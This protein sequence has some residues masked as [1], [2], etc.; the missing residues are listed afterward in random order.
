M[1]L[2]SPESLETGRRLLQ[3]HGSWS[4]V[5]EHSRRGKSGVFVVKPQN[6]GK[7]VELQRALDK[8]AG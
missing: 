4:G 6:D 8:L 2:N 3:A 1:K 7:L 5:R